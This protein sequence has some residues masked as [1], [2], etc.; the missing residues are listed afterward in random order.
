MDNL[1]FGDC[2]EKMKDYPD[3]YFDM[4]LNDPPYGTTC[5]KWDSVID[6]KEMWKQLIRVT[7]QNSAILMFA[8]NPFDKL[9]GA[10]NIAM[11]KYD[12][13]WIKEQGTGQL[14]AKKQ[15]LR[16][17]ENILVFYRKQPKYN[18]QFSEGDPY[19]IK[20]N[21]K[22]EGLYLYN[23][24]SEKS[25]TINTGGRYP[26]SEL[27]YNRELRNRFHPTQ[28]PIALLEYLIRTY[29]DEND[30]VLD[31]TMGG[32]STGIA[33]KK[34]NRNFYGIENNQKYF[35]IAVKRISEYPLTNF[36]N[37]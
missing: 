19:T 21:I 36:N 33:C 2:L 14:N 30:N 11:Y 35:D 25:E 16:K 29:T 32:G 15:P 3:N 34:S 20:R 13:V 37:L 22:T 17:H 24:I 10:S 8:A 6:F 27:R 18:P 7:K 12:W 9:L 5:Q 4:V 31:F 23:G 1:A 28:K 26:T